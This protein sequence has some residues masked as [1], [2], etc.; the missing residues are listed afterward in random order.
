M[1]CFFM[2]L[3]K[4]AK[5]GSELSLTVDPG[6][7]WTLPFRIPHYILPLVSTLATVAVAELGFKTG[8]N[9]NSDPGQSQMIKY[10]FR[11]MMPIIGWFSTT[12]PSGVLVYWVTTNIYSVLQLAVLQVPIVRQWA[13]FPKRIVHRRIRM[14]RK[15]RGSWIGSSR[16][17]IN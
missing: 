14:E 7:L 5:S 6:G 10:V 3:E 4:I 2:A 9:A 11:G 13:R 12:F 8:T 1:F 16:R 15:V 17:E